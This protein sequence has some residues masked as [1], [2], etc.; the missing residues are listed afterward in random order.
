VSL[1]ELLG[2]IV[3]ALDRAGIPS[4]LDWAHLR[5]WAEEL[6][7]ADALDDLGGSQ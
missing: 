2:S 1:A 3:R 5:R 7:V 4:R 6:G